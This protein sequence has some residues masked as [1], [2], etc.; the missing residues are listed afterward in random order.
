MIHHVHHGECTRNITLSPTS[1]KRSQTIYSFLN[2]Y[3]M[4]TLHFLS[5]TFFFFVDLLSIEQ[6]VIQL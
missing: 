4:S 3:S 6:N 2:I 1:K 5:V